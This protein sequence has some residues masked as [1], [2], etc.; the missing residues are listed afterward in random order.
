VSPTGTDVYADVMN[1][2]PEVAFSK[3]L[4]RADW[5]DSRIAS[6]EFDRWVEANRVNAL[7]GRG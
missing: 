2:I 7:T 4:T 6:D 5:A 3:T 1:E